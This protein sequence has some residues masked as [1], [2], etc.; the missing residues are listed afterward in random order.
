MKVVLMADRD[1]IEYKE[2]KKILNEKK[3]VDL[4]VDK[5]FD[6][7]KFKKSKNEVK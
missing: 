2:K 6:S 7:N 4:D 3:E 1:E 5:E